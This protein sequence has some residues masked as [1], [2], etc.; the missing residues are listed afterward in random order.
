MGDPD[1]EHYPSGGHDFAI[2]EP[3]KKSTRHTIKIQHQSVFKLRHHS[4]PEG[5]SI[6]GE[7]FKADWSPRLGIRN[8]PFGAK[9]P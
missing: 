7:G 4:L 9:V 1:R 8:S 6:G 2:I 3:E 5:K